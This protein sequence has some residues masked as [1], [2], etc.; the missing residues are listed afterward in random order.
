[1]WM[2]RLVLL[3]GLLAAA[4]PALGGSERPA[5]ELAHCMCTDRNP[6]Q[7]HHGGQDGRRNGDLYDVTCFVSSVSPYE[8]TISSLPSDISSLHLDCN[9]LDKESSLTSGFFERF[10]SLQYLTISGC[11][12]ASLDRRSFSGLQK[13]SSLVISKCILPEVDTTIL[14]ELQ[15]LEQL[16]IVSSGLRV[17]PNI[18]HL[19]NLQYVNVSHN[20]LEWMEL[21]SEGETVDLKAHE[22]GSY[23]MFTNMTLLDISYNKIKTFPVDLI[24][25]TPNLEKFLLKNNCIQNI[26]FPGYVKLS[27]LK[28]LDARENNLEIVQFESISSACHLHQLRLEGNGVP[29]NYE[30]ISSLGDLEELRLRNFAVNDT[31]WDSLNAT[32][33]YKLD[34]VGNSLETVN[35]SRMPSLAILLIGNNLVSY[36]DQSTF[37]QQSNLIALNASHND[38]SYLPN[39][40]FSQTL[41]LLAVDL[42][43]NKLTDLGPDSLEGLQHLVHIDLSHNAIQRLPYSVF[44]DLR[45]LQGL[46]IEGNQL[47][48]L[49]SFSNLGSL[50]TLNVSEN[51]LIVLRF[52]DLRG[53]SS[54]QWLHANDNNITSLPTGLLSNSPHLL[55]ADFHNN[56]ISFVGSFEAHPSL[57]VLR[58][59]DNLIPDYDGES[60]FVN[61]P[62]LAYLF[63]DGNKLTTLRPRMFP[64]SVQYLILDRNDLSSV[65][66][67]SLDTLPHL[68]RV[69]LMQNNYVLSL[70]AW[71]VNKFNKHSPKPIF[72]LGFSVLRCDC[73]MAYLKAWA[74]DRYTTS[75]LSLF[76]PE[77]HN[78]HL[79][80]C[81]T[82][83]MKKGEYRPFPE[84]SISEFAC[85]YNE[86]WCDIFCKC[87]STLK[88]CSCAFTCPTG[89][90][91]AYAGAA[92]KK[93]YVH[94]RCEGR[95]FRQVPD[96]IPSRTTHLRLDG[97]KL[98][99]IKAIDLSHLRDTEDIFLNGSSIESIENGTFENITDLLTLRLNDNLLVSVDSNLF[100]NMSQLLTLYL[101]NNMIAYIEMSAFDGMS[102]LQIL[103]MHNNKLTKMDQLPSLP[104]ITA[105]TLSSNPWSCDCSAG[106]TVFQFVYSFNDAILDRAEMCCAE[107]FPDQI[108][109][110][111]L[112]TVPEFQKDNQTTTR[113]A[114]SNFSELH[115]SSN[116]LSDCRLV[117]NYN[118]IDACSQPG[119]T[120][121][122]ARGSSSYETP[123]IVVALSTATV[124]LSVIAAVVVV[125]LW[126]RHE[127]QA[128]MFVKLGV[129]MFDKK[130]VLDKE[131]AGALRPFDAFISYSSNDDEFVDTTLLPA[132]ERG[133]RHYRVCVHYRDFP[134]GA[135]ITDTIG[136][137]IGKSS[138]TILLLSRNFLESEWCRFE[139]QMAHLHILREG[140][141]RLIIVLLEDIPEE[142]LDPD[143]KVHMKAKSFLRYSDP[144]FWEKLYFA[145]PDVP[146]GGRADD[147]DVFRGMRILAGERN[148][149]ARA[150]D[151]L[152][153]VE[154]Q[155]NDGVAFERST[156]SCGG[157]NVG[158]DEGQAQM[159]LKEGQA[160]IDLKEGQTQM[161]LE[162]D[163]AQMAL[164]EGQAHM[165]LDEGQA[166]M[167]LN[168]NQV[169]L[170]VNENHV[171]MAFSHDDFHNFKEDDDEETTPVVRTESLY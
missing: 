38:I 17:F 83:F 106:D 57:A 82:P 29:L 39:G 68:V 88:N 51:Q 55:Q 110:S 94:I 24:S 56:K 100:G 137:A 121:R 1:M 132:L 31:I 14:H 159:D 12:I 5:C 141:E 87:C 16:S 65:L 58:L 41:N 166:Q 142:M 151:R 6:A 130:A 143:L 62:A 76:Y 34:L 54:L 133:D 78:L 44:R 9:V 168:E 19:T 45:S 161:E 96:N 165:T 91:C 131:G 33:L 47:K 81:V 90:W 123:P 150:K 111:S 163:Q 8:A 122:A 48:F 120:G 98:T 84:V 103:T 25:S 32:T 158:L 23:P 40:V 21:V 145:L 15:A 112:P 115:V 160:Q 127:L 13:L 28:V 97:N 169:K 30:G 20:D 147:H 108:A 136:S 63:L 43:H 72:D 152:G 70:P 125:A 146:E 52:S 99:H 79:A 53:L 101:H 89:C 139:F 126:K 170:A 104:E 10:S 42:S 107:T 11:K 80:Y 134:V 128:W 156:K 86:T 2:S 75:F 116:Q 49:P 73:F 114:G 77:F 4:H 71:S 135:Q 22:Y 105:I 74:E 66:M 7:I 27:S 102:S 140:A 35:V 171:N 118:Y 26:S 153:K 36:L 60:P 46:K 59:D 117:I 3:S 69:S 155:H 167:A 64:V 50:L 95:Q 149:R 113:H 92:Y 61:L 148:D 67:D 37:M 109:S 93:R 154:G 157:M 138:R 18:S 119:S 85:E 164:K 162:K 124:I 144:W 129:R